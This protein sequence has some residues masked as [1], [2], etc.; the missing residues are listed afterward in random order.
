MYDTIGTTNQKR[1]ARR[2]RKRRTRREHPLPFVDQTTTKRVKRSQEGERERLT[3]L[4]I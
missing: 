1:R 4:M 3:A 2:R